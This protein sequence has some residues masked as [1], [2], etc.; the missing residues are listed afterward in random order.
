VSPAA[1][2]AE[3]STQSGTVL[4]PLG[5]GGLRRTKALSSRH[6][7]TASSAGPQGHSTNRLWGAILGA[8]R[9]CGLSRGAVHTIHLPCVP[10]MSAH[11]RSWARPRQRCWS[12]SAR[13]SGRLD[14]PRRPVPQARLLARGFVHPHVDSPR[15]A[16]WCPCSSALDVATLPRD[17]TALAAEGAAVNAFHLALTST[18]PST[19]RRACLVTV[20]C[21]AL[22]DVRDRPVRRASPGRR[23]AVPM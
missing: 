20:L 23:L 6:V 3:P 9:N 10:F 11:I 1:S 7:D 18:I 4:P 12:Q 13:R 2:S 21:S 14:D 5:E 17:L 15:P 19:G 8:R 22:A 16:G